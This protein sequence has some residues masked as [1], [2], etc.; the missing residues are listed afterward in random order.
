V[1][2]RTIYM[3]VAAAFVVGVVAAVFPAWRAV[4]IRIADGLRQI[5]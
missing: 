1:D 5:G 4:R 3:D 2:I